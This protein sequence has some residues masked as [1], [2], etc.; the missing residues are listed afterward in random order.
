MASILLLTGQ[1]DSALKEGI[2]EQQT[3]IAVSNAQNMQRWLTMKKSAMEKMIQE[4]AE[5]FYGGD[6]EQIMPVL[7]VIASGDPDS[8]AYAF[9]DTA[10][11]SFGSDGYRSNRSDTLELVKKQEGV[12]FTDIV[13][14][15][16]KEFIVVSATIRDGQGEFKGML[17]AVMDTSVLLRDIKDI[18]GSDSS[19]ANMIS[20]SGMYLAH[21]N[22][23]LIGKMVEESAEKDT[24][25]LFKQKVLVDPIGFV[26]Y[27][28]ADGRE[29]LASFATVDASG[30]RIVVAGENAE[31]M[32]AAGNAKQLAYIIIA[33]SVVLVLSV[34][35]LFSRFML[36]PI[37]MISALLQKA[38][39]GDL[40]ER[41]PLG[42]NDEIGILKRN[43]NGMLD[44]FSA[45]IDKISLAVRHTAASSDQLNHAAASTARSSEQI[46]DDVIT[47][48]RGSEAQHAGA[49]QSA[50]AMEEINVGISRIAESS[51]S[52]AGNAS[53]TH[54]SILS[55]RAEVD[56][57]VTQI[58]KI[59]DAFHTSADMAKR[60]DSRS[61]EIDEIVKHISRIAAQT[62]IL[63]LN[64]GIEAAR[65][66]EHGKGFAVVAVEVKNLAEQTTEAAES[67]FELIRDI[68]VSTGQTS[69]TM[70]QG[71]DEVR[72]GVEQINKVGSVFEEIVT[73]VQEVN[74]QIQEVSAAAEQISASS[75]EV[76]SSMSET[77][78]VHSDSLQRLT[79]V[80]VLAS[81][82]KSAMSEI[83]SSSDS[84]KALANELTE[85]VSEFRTNARE[86]E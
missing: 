60:L 56:N 75:E 55:G 45:M 26:S 11:N 14:D 39:G 43:I 52:V 74:E 65:A 23:E 63:A 13:Q 47:V 68:Q 37:Y 82:Q 54:Q 78:N 42:A 84:L 40:S 64:A 33:V 20:S 80:S 66:G 31:L 73:L 30:W 25:A 1:Y 34:A 24:A 8:F 50:R 77:I 27:K 28:E 41:L 81:E 10:G 53:D 7:K 6:M 86:I 5:L 29:M 15:S 22:E 32:S 48:T 3:T 38:A 76:S 44:S 70:D 83:A 67:I 71:L 72:K 57:V 35:L 9:M 17:S 12:S 2:R 4:N 61:Q 79:A 36:K 18:K 85:M 51:S 62:N 21:Q 16:G 58:N 49:V 69:Q 59:S 19:H 46:S